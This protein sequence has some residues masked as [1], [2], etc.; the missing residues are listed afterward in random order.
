MSV[1]KEIKL[2]R[3]ALRNRSFEQICT[4]VVIQAEKVTGLN[5]NCCIDSDRS[6]NAGEH[7]QSRHYE[8]VDGRGV[9]FTVDIT[10]SYSAKETVLIAGV[11]EYLLDNDG[12]ISDSVLIAEGKKVLEN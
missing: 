8:A 12:D 4:E 10:L 11:C 3:V 1:L 6:Q 5:F 2:G 7:W 9:F